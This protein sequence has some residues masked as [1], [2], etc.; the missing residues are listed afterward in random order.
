MWRKTT[1]ES[2]D[3][4]QRPHASHMHIQA[5]IS[6]LRQT[7]ETVIRGREKIWQSENRIAWEKSS[8][9]M[10]SIHGANIAAK[11]LKTRRHKTQFGLMEQRLLGR[12]VMLHPD[13][14]IWCSF[15]VTA[16]FSM[17]VTKISTSQ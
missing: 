10:L 7:E 14:G 3:L 2:W 16:K 17:E 8:A 1:I 11:R 5:F 9:E 13:A 12:Y 15:G 6:S 4:G